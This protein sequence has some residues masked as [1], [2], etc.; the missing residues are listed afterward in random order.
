MSTDLTTED[1]GKRV[2]D[3]DGNEI[4]VVTDDAIQLREEY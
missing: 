2:I 3:G 1:A 4:R